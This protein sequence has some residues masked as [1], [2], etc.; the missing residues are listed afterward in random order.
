MNI[1]IPSKDLWRASASSTGE[2]EFG[3]TRVAIVDH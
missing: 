3:T 1:L 2:F